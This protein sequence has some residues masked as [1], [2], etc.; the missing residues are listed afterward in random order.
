LAGDEDN[1]LVEVDKIKKVVGNRNKKAIKM[2]SNHNKCIAKR[3]FIKQIYDI[4]R[5]QGFMVSVSQVAVSTG[6]MSITAA[7][8]C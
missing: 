6:L 7:Q 2:T 5:Y 4:S 8:C 3:F 1:G